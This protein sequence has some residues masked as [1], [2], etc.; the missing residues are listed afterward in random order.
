MLKP[1]AMCPP[2]EGNEKKAKPR[3]RVVNPRF[4]ARAIRIAN[5]LAGPEQAKFAQGTKSGKLKEGT[6]AYQ[7]ARA[8]MEAERDKKV[9]TFFDVKHK[10]GLKYSKKEQAS[11]A[12]KIAKS[13]EG[14]GK[15]NVGRRNKAFVKA[16]MNEVPASVKKMVGEKAY[17]KL[18]RLATR[19]GKGAKGGGKKNK[20]G[21]Y[22]VVGGRN[23]TEVSG[24]TTKTTKMG[25]YKQGYAKKGDP[26]KASGVQKGKTQYDTAFRGEGGNPRAKGA[27]PKAG[28]GEKKTPTKKGETKAPTKKG[29]TKAPAK[30]KP[31]K[32]A[33]P[34]KDAKSAPAKN[35]EK[36]KVKLTAEAKRL[37]DAAQARKQQQ[38]AKPAAAPKPAAKPAPQKATPERRTTADTTLQP[39]VRT[40]KPVKLKTSGVANPPPKGNTTQ[41]R[42]KV[43]ETNIENHATLD[44]KVKADG[45]QSLTSADRQTYSFL[46]RIVGDNRAE[47]KNTKWKK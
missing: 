46:S 44:K 33:K 36:P 2:D 22:A 11:N 43:L 3:E 38:Q 19:T 13:I 7:K 47:L 21:K 24:K 17:A 9:S 40:I 29:E 5:E 8:K 23:V 37:V 14:L 18:Q 34:K 12:K 45:I 42:K 27:A 20:T 39:E 6:K 30:E 26:K 28:K 15:G 35:E 41:A 31:K 10:K 4:Q 25:A 16:L 32:E 1:R